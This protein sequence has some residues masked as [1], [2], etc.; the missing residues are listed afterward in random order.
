M[1]SLI[2]FKLEQIHQRFVSISKPNLGSIFL[3]FQL[4][5][6]LENCI[7]RVE[8]ANYQNY[9]NKLICKYI[10]IYILIYI[11]IYLFICIYIWTKKKLKISSPKRRER[12]KWKHTNEGGKKKNEDYVLSLF[13]SVILSSLVMKS[14]LLK[15]TTCPLVS[16]RTWTRLHRQWYVVFDERYILLYDLSYRLLLTIML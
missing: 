12:T 11:Y 3:Y 14:S 4:M 15:E 1:W 9:S 10:Y 5:N 13:W 7:S 16:D 8:I 2:R 6:S